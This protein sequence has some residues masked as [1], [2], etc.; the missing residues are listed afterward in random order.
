MVQYYDTIKGCIFMAAYYMYINILPQQEPTGVHQFAVTTLCSIQCKPQGQGPPKLIS[1]IQYAA[2][3]QDTS[4][5]ILW[6]VR[7]SQ[8]ASGKRKYCLQ[9]GGENGPQE[10]LII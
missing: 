6:A 5:T 2:I 3:Y 10:I 1:E 9:D 4:A 7:P 8:T